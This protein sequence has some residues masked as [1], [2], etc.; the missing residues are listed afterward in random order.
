MTNKVYEYVTNAIVEKLEQGVIPWQRPW[1]SLTSNGLPIS[2]VTKKAYR[3][4]NTFLLESGE[5]LTFK[6]IQAQGGN[7]KRGEKG[8]MVVFYRMMESTREVDGEEESRSFPFLRYYTVFEVA[9]CEG[10]ERKCPVEVTDDLEIVPIEKAEAI[11]KGYKNAPSIRHIGNSACYRPATDEIRMPKKASFFSMEEYY[12]T[13]FHEMGHSTGHATRLAREGI[14]HTSGMRTD[15]YAKEELVAEM[16]AAMLSGIAGIELKVIDNS[17]SYIESWMRRLKAD[18][19]L[20]VKTASLAQ[21]ASDLI[22][23]KED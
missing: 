7:V 9:Q 20:I 1:K 8:H 22:L 14:T 11:K 6:Q 19:S 21:K 3:G 4:I 16:T 10:I 23:A 17:A 2:W 12:S 18:P 5:Y 13:L 15:S